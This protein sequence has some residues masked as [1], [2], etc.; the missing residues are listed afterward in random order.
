MNI[1]EIHGVFADAILT[2]EAD[3][4]IFGSFWGRDTSIREFQG[5]LTLGSSE[6]GLSA[7]N[8]VQPIDDGATKKVYVKIGNVDL[9]EQ[10]TG[11]VQTDI[12]GEMV[13]CWLYRQEIIKP[14]LANHRAILVN[15]LEA[16]PAHL[17]DAIKVVCPI[18][19]LD[20][21]SEALLPVMIDNG[22]IK[23]MVGINQCGT[24]IA[25]DE[26]L[27]ASIVK[28]ACHERSITIHP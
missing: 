16:N 25:I 1:P 9:I 26:E 5:R 21:W 8:L 3:N 4:L 2:D 27:M 12:L 14:D 24:Q 18:P 13:H 10:M 7:L 11:R 17:W 28:K 15:S 23:K 19:L 20:H 6:G 22:M